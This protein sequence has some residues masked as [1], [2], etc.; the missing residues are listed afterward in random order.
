MPSATA[1]VFIH[2]I[3]LE[4]KVSNNVFLTVRSILAHEELEHFLDRL[5]SVN[6]D[7]IQTDVITD[8]VL[9]FIR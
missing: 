5:V 9:E 4:P 7:R 6:L 2:D 8:E 1:L 3:V